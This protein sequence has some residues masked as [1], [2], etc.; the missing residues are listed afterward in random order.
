LIAREGGDELPGLVPGRRVNGFDFP[1]INERGDIL[2]SA[3]LDYGP[4]HNHGYWLHTAEGELVPLLQTGR[5]APGLPD[6]VMLGESTYVEGYPDELDIGRIA[7]TGSGLALLEFHLAGAGVDAT[8][9]RALYLVDRMGRPTL[10]IRRGDAIPMAHEDTRTIADF[11][12]WYGY[13]DGY[14]RSPINDR[15]DVVAILEFVDGTQAVAKL[16]V[17]EPE[18]WTMLAVGSL[19]LL[20][21]QKLRSAGRESA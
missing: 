17:P 4:I 19:A 18:A 9:D 13:R 11:R 8:N 6:G 7:L 3:I 1:L 20:V 5:P 2:L 10:V 14:G 16:T 12:V 15:G 21:T